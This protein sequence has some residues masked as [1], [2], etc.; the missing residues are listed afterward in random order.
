MMSK[1]LLAMCAFL[2]HEKKSNRQA[3]IE[4]L[5]GSYVPQ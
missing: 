4:M 5:L 3:L 2:T 1:T